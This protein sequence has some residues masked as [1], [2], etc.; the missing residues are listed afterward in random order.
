MAAATVDLVAVSQSLQGSSNNSTI[1]ANFTCKTA[2]GVAVDMTTWSTFKII[3][4]ANSPAPALGQVVTPNVATP[5]SGNLFIELDQANLAAFQV[6]GTYNY[7]V[8]G[9]NNA[10]SP[11][12]QTIGYGQ[13]TFLPY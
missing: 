5:T 2:A 10:A 7:S 6:P 13:L 9:T 3:I 8:Y 1:R 12:T 11:G 4:S